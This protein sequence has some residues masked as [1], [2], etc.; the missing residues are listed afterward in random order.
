M[1]A[2]LITH[3]NVTLDPML[4]ST[5]ID[6]SDHHPILSTLNVTPNPPPPPTTVTYRLLNKIDYHK[7]INDLN[8]TSLV[9][10]SPSTLTDMSDSHFTT[11]RSLQDIHAPVDTKTS[12]SSRTTPSP[13]ITSHNLKLK[14]SRRRLK[15]LMPLLSLH[16]RFQNLPHRNSSLQQNHRCRKKNVTF[17][18]SSFHLP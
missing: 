13:W 15:P 8:S 16:R 17:H 5:V 18:L 4:I 1:A 12:N 9:T 14:S 10:N 2:R 11:L 6:T 3:S 7:F